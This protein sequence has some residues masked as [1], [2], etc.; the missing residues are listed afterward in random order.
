MD[1]NIPDFGK[2]LQDAMLAGIKSLEREMPIEAKANA[3]RLGLY[4][5]GAL[6]SSL[7]TRVRGRR[8]QLGTNLDYP[9]IYNFGG[10]IH[11]QATHKKG[12][13]REPMNRA[14]TKREAPLRIVPLAKDMRVWQVKQRQFFG[15][16]DAR[17]CILRSERGVGRV[18]GGR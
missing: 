4:R 14:K 10:T 1:N 11:Q 2:Q 18:L 3:R 17:N 9:N 16:D 12:P 7:N 15:E 13:P 6:V 5:T 8:I